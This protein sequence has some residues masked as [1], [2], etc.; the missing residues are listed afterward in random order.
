MIR[1]MRAVPGHANQ[2][3]PRARKLVD[4]KSVSTF[5]FLMYKMGMFPTIGGTIS[6]LDKPL[7]SIIIIIIIIHIQCYQQDI[8]HATLR[9]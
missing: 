6:L 3:K 9:E 5:S 7:R 1:A 4:G 2:F 8:E